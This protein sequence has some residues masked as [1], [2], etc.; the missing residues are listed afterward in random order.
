MATIDTIRH[1]VHTTNVDRCD[2]LPVARQY[3]RT[4]IIFRW[5]MHDCR[6]LMY[7]FFDPE[8][9][10]DCY[11]QQRIDIAAI[12]Y[13]LIREAMEERLGEDA[14]LVFRAGS[15]KGDDGSFPA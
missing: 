15:M 5:V 4:M 9:K 8:K 6:M 12:D 11:I 14:H 7:E 2:V 1:I 3:P 10:T 13:G